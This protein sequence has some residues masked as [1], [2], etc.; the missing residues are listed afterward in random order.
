MQMVPKCPAVLSI[1]GWHTGESPADIIQRKRAAC[2]S[3]QVNV[4]A[5]H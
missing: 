2:R 3:L 4:R 5:G 1:T